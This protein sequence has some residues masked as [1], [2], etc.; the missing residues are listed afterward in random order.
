[1]T[2]LPA[3]A[4]HSIRLQLTKSSDKTTVDNVL[5]LTKRLTA[6]LLLALA[7]QLTS[8]VAVQAA[9]C[10]DSVYTWKC[11]DVFCIINRESGNTDVVNSSGHYGRWQISLYWHKDKVERLIGRQLTDYEAGQALLDPAINWA[12]AWYLYLDNNGRG[13]PGW[14][15]WNG[16]CS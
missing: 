16:G 14:G 6:V 11:S 2:N 7:L 4:F 12:V 15:H 10:D 9:P 3:K 5:Q 13:Y 1:M 8:S